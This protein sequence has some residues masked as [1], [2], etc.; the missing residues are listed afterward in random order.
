MRKRGLNYSLEERLMIINP[1]FAANLRR[2]FQI[3]KYWNKNKQIYKKFLLAD[4]VSSSVH[5]TFFARTSHVHP[6]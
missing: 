4:G 6:T 2:F 1:K 3:T 5:C